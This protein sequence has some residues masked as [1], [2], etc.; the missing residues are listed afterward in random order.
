MKS[1]PR[2]ST[3][4]RARSAKYLRGLGDPTRLTVLELLAENGEMN[5]SQ[6]VEA[7]GV[8]QGR[9]SDHLA[10]LKWCHYVESRR[11]GKYVYYV[12]KDE[13]VLALLSLIQELASDHADD[14]DACLRI[15]DA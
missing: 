6:L 12:I 9:L 2:A 4:S 8:P 15:P 5:V 10:C 3:A 11:E 7:I 14:L 13:R 1:K